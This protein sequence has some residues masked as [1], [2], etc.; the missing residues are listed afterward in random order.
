MATTI[1]ELQ[2][3]IS[4]TT[5]DFNRQI[6]GV[7]GK[8]SELGATGET[9][10]KRLFSGFEGIGVAATKALKVG[11]VGGIAAI[12]ASVPSAVRRID[13]LNNSARTFENMGFKTD[14]AKRAV[15]ELERSV[16]GL[17]TPLDSAMRGM[18]SLAATYGDIELG[19][20]V[21]SS[22]NNAILGFGGSANEVD[23]AIQQLSQLPM[24]GPLDA[25]TWNSLRNSGLTPVLVAM[26]KEFGMSVSEMK[27]A[28]GDG[29]LTV[30]DFTKKLID[31]NKNGGGGLKNLE[32]IARDSTAGIGTGF[33]NM[34]TAISKGIASIMEAIGS[35]NISSAV[36]TIGQAFKTTLEAIAAVI[37]FVRANSDF[38]GPL[39]AGIATVVALLTAWNIVTKLVAVA[40]AALNIVLA[41]NPIGIVI[42]AIAA[43]TAGLVYFFTKTDT[44]K[45]IF[46]TAMDFISKAARGAVDFIVNT[47][48]SVVGFFE[49]LWE[50]VKNVFKAFV[51]FVKKWWAVIFLGVITGG[52]AIIVGLVIKNWDTIKQNSKAV[53]DA[54]VG[55]FKA[56]PSKIGGFF[57]SAKNAV[58]VVWNSIPGFF[59]GVVNTI[60]SVF[61]RVV[62]YV[63][64]AFSRAVS[65]IKS[66]NWLD[67]G[68]NIIRGIGQG[69]ANMGGWLAQKAKDAVNNAKEQLKSFLGIH[70]PSRVM[71]DEVGKMLGL[72]I[73][74]GIDKSSKH[75][76]N[77]AVGSAKSIVGAY[78]S[79]STAIPSAGQLSSRLEMSL[80]N[81]GMNSPDDRPIH[82]TVKVGE[83]TLVD[84]IVKGINDKSFMANATIL[85]V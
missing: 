33:A 62:S 23:N 13:T 49:A 82:V 54:I 24:D 81:S 78:S 60:G 40:Q 16:T 25:Q 56:I 20:Q 63:K 45:K 50:G 10:N 77:S 44:G 22:L 68:M 15:D 7:K 21:F 42:L 37:T 4:A 58:V 57:T 83:E 51:D 65:A 55:F 3:L 64:N 11:V 14:V 29:T 19:Q 71:R 18:T 35:A 59:S 1:D 75:A 36:T 80:D 70:S 32:A 38:F 31:M 61:G 2:V 17:P 28:F 53:L 79:L 66:I 84:R 5:K 46:S 27:A 8:L 69:I 34:R 73:A 26:S 85:E 47:F 43:L 67:V 72:G 12:A 39:I 48:Q 9:T 41:A 76:V 52:M 30:E 74:E 6:D